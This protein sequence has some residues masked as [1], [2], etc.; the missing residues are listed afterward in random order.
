M[1]NNK[2]G[3]KYICFDLFRFLKD[4]YSFASDIWAMGITMYELMTLH[5]PFEGKSREYIRN[6]LSLGEYPYLKKED[7]KGLYDDELVDS[8]NMMLTVCICFIL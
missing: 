4:R 3:T 2:F 8:V 7:I 1:Y 6:K 5:R